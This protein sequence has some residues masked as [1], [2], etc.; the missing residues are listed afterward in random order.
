MK[1]VIFL[2]YNNLFIYQVLCTL[3]YRRRSLYSLLRKSLIFRHPRNQSIQGHWRFQQVKY[4]GSCLEMNDFVSRMSK[5]ALCLAVLNH[6]RNDFSFQHKDLC[7]IIGI[8][9]ISHPVQSMKILYR[10]VSYF[11]IFNCS[12]EVFNLSALLLIFDYWCVLSTNTYLVTWS[13]FLIKQSAFTT[14]YLQFAWL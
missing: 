8:T 4:L 10:L 14:R 12:E 1:L 7:V 13:S 6:C 9:D 2:L 3:I 11:S 5:F